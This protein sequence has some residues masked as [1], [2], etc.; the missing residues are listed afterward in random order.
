MII[1]LY[2][3][4]YIYIDFRIVQL[5]FAL[6]QML[7]FIFRERGW[8]GEREEKYQCMRETLISCLSHDPIWGS[9]PQTRHVP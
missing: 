4:I 5:C 8:E 1:Y 2:F 6:F 3:Y 9:G 7:L